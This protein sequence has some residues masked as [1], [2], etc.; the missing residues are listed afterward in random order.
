MSSVS[1]SD[2]AEM[3]PTV[4]SSQLSVTATSSPAKH[5]LPVTMKS[6]NPIQRTAKYNFLDL[7]MSTIKPLVNMSFPVIL[8]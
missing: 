6:T 5:N 7:G 3:P 1:D 2:D 4:K 8:Q